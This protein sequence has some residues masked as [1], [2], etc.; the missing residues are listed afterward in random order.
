MG[1]AERSQ[2]SRP[3]PTRRGAL[4]RFALLDRHGRIQGESWD[5][6]EE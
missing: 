4:R 6:P 5:Q 2:A 3:T 1:S